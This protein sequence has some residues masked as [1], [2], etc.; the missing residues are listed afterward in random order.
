MKQIISKNEA[1]MRKGVLILLLLL[2]LMGIAHAQIL[3][4]SYSF[5]DGTTINFPSDFLPFNENYDSVS[6]ANNQTDIAISVVFARN[7][8]SQRL[9]T[10]PQILNFH[11]ANPEIYSIG[12][13]EAIL[14]GERD[15]IRFTRLVEGENPYSEIYIVLPVGANNSVAIVRIQP[16]VEGG[17]FELSEEALAMQIVESI[18]F[19]DI[20]GTL[21]TTLG[22]TF[23]FG[24]GLLIEHTG[25]WTADA[26][27]SSLTS[28]FATIHLLAFTPE[29]LA[30][31]NRK[32]DPIEV[33]Y[34][35]VFHPND[36]TLLFNPEELVFD[37]I[38][39]REGVRYAVIDT[40]DGE[41]VQRSYFVSL[42]E[43]GTVAALDIQTRVGF[44]ILDDPDTADM[45]QT[46]RPEGA[47][48]PVTMM[49]LG[50]SF[51]LPSATVHYPD[52]WRA[53]PAEE[54]VSLDSLDVNVYIR[55][56]SADEAADENYPDDLSKALLEL[57]EPIDS[58]IELS[59]DNVVE[60]PLE[61]GRP[62]VQISYTETEEGRSYPRR[63]M[64]IL[65]EDN[66]VVFVS[67]KPQEGVIELTAENEA[68]VRAIL[69]TISPR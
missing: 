27:S 56:F 64:L 32:A 65:L 38:R 60:V 53:R 66:S 14:L 55:A 49:A 57:T 5:V 42:M 69:N 4:D 50:S 31:S 51:N 36:E 26:A 44:A 68:E 40:V 54:G 12:A 17:V 15:A 3:S 34:Y 9:E 61:N 19:E 11:L 10:L 28:D 33:L 30:A 45:I 21:S 1:T 22:N 58:S 59:A 35:E 23:V 16:N 13:E 20:R 6:L 43:N 47:L 39:G 67:I 48:P 7:I 2:S 24:D 37:T 25:V 52:Y 63:V 8:E 18:H 29:E 62:A 41:P 46:L